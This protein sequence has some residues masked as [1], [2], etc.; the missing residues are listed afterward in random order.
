MKQKH[1]TRNELAQVFI[2][3]WLRLNFSVCGDNGA[4]FDADVVHDKKL[5]RATRDQLRREITDIKLNIK[6]ILYQYKSLMDDEVQMHNR[7][8][9]KK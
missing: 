7:R 1:A 6:S 5:N 9:D 4:L 3:I 2:D 8:C